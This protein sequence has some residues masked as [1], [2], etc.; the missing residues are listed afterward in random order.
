MSNVVPNVSAWVAVIA[1]SMVQEELVHLRLP[2][3]LPTWHKDSILL[4]PQAS[5]GIEGQPIINLSHHR[6][7]RMISS[8]L[9]L[10]PLVPDLLM[11]HLPTPP[12][13]LL[14]HLPIQPMVVALHQFLVNLRQVRRLLC[15]LLTLSFLTSH[16]HQTFSIS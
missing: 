7:L 8:S 14:Q 15:L 2:L 5:K 1:V 12:L 9:E 4:V 16:P 13:Q 3:L 10:N 6:L 11:L